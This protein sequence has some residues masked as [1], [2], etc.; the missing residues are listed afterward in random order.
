MILWI[1]GKMVVIFREDKKEK[2]V[3]ESESGPG[4]N[5]KERALWLGKKKNS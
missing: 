2:Y 1:I 3:L 4:R 5:T